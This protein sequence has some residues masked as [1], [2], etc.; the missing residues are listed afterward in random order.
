MK[1]QIT[2]IIIFFVLFFLFASCQKEDKNEEVYNVIEDFYYYLNEKKIDSIKYISTKKADRYFEFVFNIGHDLVIIDSINI[3][4]SLI[5]DS[6]AKIDVETF[7]TYGNKI[8]YHWSLVKRNNRWKIDE[9]DGFKDQNV[10]T[11]EDIEYTKINHPP[12]D[13]VKEQKNN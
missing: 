13:S 8:I 9:L 5:E 7:D 6:T 4:Q 12:K 10:L 11:E 1:K 3:I 2:Y